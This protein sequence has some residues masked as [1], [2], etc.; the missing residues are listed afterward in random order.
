MNN[1][2]FKIIQFILLV[3]I[4]LP[5]NL[6]I[7]PYLQNATPNSMYILW[8]TDSESESIVEWG[9]QQFLT[10]SATGSSISNYG[11]SKIHTVQLTGLL[12]S[13]R[14]FYRVVV[15][16]YESYS[17]LYNFITPPESS[18]EESFRLIAM[19][20]MQRDSSNPDKFDEIVH[21]GIIDYISE[22]HSDDIA[23]ELAMVLV[24]GDLV[25]TGNSYYQ[26][27]DHFFGPAQDLLSYVPAY[28]VFGNHEQNTDYYIKYFHLPENGSPGYEEHWYYTDY[29]NLRVIGLDSNGGYQ[30]QAQLDWLEDVLT[31]AC[32]NENIDFV[33]AQLHHPFK[34]ELWTPGESNY[35]G[36]VI[37]R[38]ESF[39]DEC[40]KPS[41]HF[42]GH[43]HGY[44]RGQ[45]QDHNHLWVNV[46][47][48]GG[49]IDYWG[50]WPQADYEEF[51]V[52]QDEWGFV[53]V[54]VEAGEDPQF[55][56]KRISRGNEDIYR[57]NELR[58]QV[59]IRFNNIP[60]HQPIG[61]L[62]GNIQNPDFILLSSGE[63]IDDDGDDMMASQ[64]KVYEDCNFNL[65]PV[66]HEFINS[67]NWYYN[68]NSQESIDLT[69]LPI[70]NLSGNSSYCWKVRYRDTSLGWSEWSEPIDFQTGESQYSE[71]LLFNSDAELGTIEGWI[72]TDGYMESLE[73]Y[74]C[75]G[76]EPYNGD[77][78]FI[79]GAL[80]DTDS[81]SRAYQEIEISGYSDCINQGLAKAFYGG[82]LSNWGGDDHPELTIS[83][84]NQNGQESIINQTLDTY[85]S[86]WTPLS[87]EV[88]IP[89]GTQSIRMIL[90][91]TRY[92]GDDNDSYFDDLFL[93]IW[94]DENCLGILGDLNN[95]NNV[96]ILDVIILV[97]YVIDTE[98]SD[99]EGIDINNDG[100]IN[101]L[102]I[103]QLINIILNNN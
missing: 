13:T 72:I 84:I 56:L 62:D 45:S 44:S 4:V 21:D 49:A 87:D 98:N 70:Y 100:N 38:M 101:I 22:Y 36:D 6:I 69:E 67:E 79:V 50:E 28:P 18:S 47:T 12:P 54:D 41:I 2:I 14:Y 75:D 74:L 24:T 78:Y 9:E 96:N 40:G 3:G 5:V 15:G 39:S 94:Q 99:N 64:W 73:E 42:F 52:T 17:G 90:T 61:T 20:D 71:N 33:F 97:N 26:W 48:A 68:E 92:A 8:E 57:D 35:T 1:R 89:I 66:I 27:Q 32:S 86:F 88:F 93:R 63:F 59:I 85:N 19:S 76:V 82:Y 58:D 65:N 83:F 77:Y 80:C 37:E 10:N 95:D 25:V 102:D 34:S 43:T 30:V 29:S 11:N 81:F 51:T 23:A 46:A 55:V 91:G 53:L 31:D 16:N 60:P 7:E 103:I